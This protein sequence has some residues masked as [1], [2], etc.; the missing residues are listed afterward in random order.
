MITYLDR[1]CPTFCRRGAPDC[2]DGKV[3]AECVKESDL[4]GT[5]LRAALVVAQGRPQGPRLQAGTAEKYKNSGNE[6]RKSLKTKEVSFKTNPKPA[7]FDIQ[8]RVLN[9]RL[10]PSRS[11]S[12][13][14]TEARRGGF[15][16]EPNP[17][18][19]K[20]GERS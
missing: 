2:A 13:R 4:G 3:R 14:G 5:S 10:N 9:A 20:S 1:R 17:G 19:R 8:T 6:A 11:V 16:A 18:M 15:D 7:N 12:I